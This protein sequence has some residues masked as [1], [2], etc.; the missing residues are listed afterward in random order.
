LQQKDQSSAPPA[1]LAL[2]QKNTKPTKKSTV[3]I[4]KSRAGGCRAESKN[5][6]EED[7]FALVQLM[8]EHKPIGPHG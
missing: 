3:Q 8:E 7:S 4:S 5:F 1:S 2:T 6:T